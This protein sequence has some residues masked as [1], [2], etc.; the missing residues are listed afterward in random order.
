MAIFNP[1]EAVVQEQPPMQSTSSLIN[2]VVGVC[3][4]CKQPFGSGQTV[5]DTVYYCDS[6]R[7]SQPIPV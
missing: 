4:K 1:L 5:S 3:P 6:C 7:V 2:D